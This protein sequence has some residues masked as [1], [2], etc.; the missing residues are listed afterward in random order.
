M[1]VSL[2]ESVHHFC[3]FVS[4]IVRAEFISDEVAIKRI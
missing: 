4:F 2:K 1:P 3:S